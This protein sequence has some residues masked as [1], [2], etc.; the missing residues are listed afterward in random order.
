MRIEPLFLIIWFFILGCFFWSGA[1]LLFGF[2]D[3]II[4]YLHDDS[5]KARSF[6]LVGEIFFQTHPLT[7]ALAMFFGVLG[8][9]FILALCLPRMR[10]D[11]FKDEFYEDK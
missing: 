4:G 2:V 11:I 6:Y 7:N 9:G 10:R 3:L 8:G 1:I 5:I